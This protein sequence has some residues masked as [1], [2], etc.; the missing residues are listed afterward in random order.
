MKPVLRFSLSALPQ[1]ALIL[2]LVTALWI[3]MPQTARADL[4]IAPLRVTFQDR[5]RTAEV[6]LINTSNTKNTYR[7]G[8]THNRQMPNG[9]YEK[10]DTPLHPD[11]NPEDMIMFSPRQVSIPPGGRQKIRMSLRRPPEMP[12]GEYRAHLRFQKLANRDG[13]DD[14]GRDD[15]ASGMSMS[16]FVNLGFSVPVLVRQGPYDAQ[17]HISDVR[18]APPSGETQG[19]PQLSMTLNRTGKN[20]TIGR[21]NVYWVSPAGDETRIGRANNVVIYPELDSRQI[22]VSLQVAQ[23]QGGSLRIVYQGDGPDRHIVF[24]ET[25]IPVG[26]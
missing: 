9:R 2:P 7:V 5:D 26:Y 25:V 18:L 6:V 19:V 13:Q 4:T 11:Y 16:L 24:D 17:A 15:N 10:I 3:A 23:M 14:G 22:D 20:S 8:W 1:I 21:I 12:E